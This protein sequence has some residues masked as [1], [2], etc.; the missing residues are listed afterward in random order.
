VTAA[1]ALASHL[2]PQRLP[3]WISVALGL[4][5][6][7]AGIVGL[8][9][10]FA[11]PATYA[12]IARSN[13]F[14]TIPFLVPGTAPVERRR[15]VH[16]DLPTRVDL[17]ERTL[18]YVLS[19]DVGTPRDPTT[20]DPLFA[21]DEQQ[22][23]ADVQRV[24]TVVTIAALLAV[25]TL[26]SLLWAVSHAGRVAALRAIRDGALASAILI[27]VLAALFAVAFEPAFLAFHYLFFPQGNFLFDPA[28]SNLLALYPEA[29]WYGV[30]LRIG[31]TFVS[32]M[33]AIAIAATVALRRRATP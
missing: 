12:D 26:L 3:R 24:F 4:T 20:R 2:P 15:P 16:Y 25:A 21:L 31:V 32:A 33:A 1:T 28:T 9:L 5:F 13:G 29:Y 8:V 11:G 18:S 22:H 27:A 10:I 19:R 14:E 17:H 6:A 7:V 30:T 23:L